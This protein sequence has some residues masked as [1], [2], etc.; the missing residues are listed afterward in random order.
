MSTTPGNY[1]SVDNRPQAL[2][3]K[4]TRW[5]VVHRRRRD[6]AK[7]N[8]DGKYLLCTSDPA[9]STEDVALGYKLLLEVE[10]GWRDFKSV[11]DLRPVHHRL[12]ERIRAHI[13]LC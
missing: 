4:D 2:P 6:Q 9:L 12:E 8:L 11:L 5:A 7:A 13:V 10:R 1:V 3:A